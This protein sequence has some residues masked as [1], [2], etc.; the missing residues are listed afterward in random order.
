MVAPF[1]VDDAE[2]AAGVQVP[3]PRSYK[4]I[5]GTPH[6]IHIKERDYKKLAGDTRARS[7]GLRFEWRVQTALIERFGADY[8]AA[9]GLYFTDDSGFRVL[10]PDGILRQPAHVTVVEIKIQHMPEAWWQTRLYQDVIG[11]KYYMK[12]CAVVEVVRSFDPFMPF[13]CA[14]DK[15]D[16]VDDLVTYR[17][18]CGFGVLIWPR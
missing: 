6:D 10:I 5:Q 1:L 18:G 16:S 2:R 12:P 13:P 14:V 3:P 17:G 4:P 11:R 8:L 9:P 7:N 15:L